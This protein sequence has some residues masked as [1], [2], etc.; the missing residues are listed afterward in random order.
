MNLTLRNSQ[1]FSL[2]ILRCCLDENQSDPQRQYA[3]E[4]SLIDFQ[5]FLST[6]AESQHKTTSPKNKA[7]PVPAMLLNPDAVNLIVCGFSWRKKSARRL[8]PFKY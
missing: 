5:C 6:S 8:R 4:W 2:F 1:S 3:H 7:P